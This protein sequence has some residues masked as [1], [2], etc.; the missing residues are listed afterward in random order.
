M[1]KAISSMDDLV[2]SENTASLYLPPSPPIQLWLRI[3]MHD[4]NKMYAMISIPRFDYANIYNSAQFSPSWLD[5][6]I[7]MV[8]LPFRSAHV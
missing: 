4:K 5:I 2:S 8:S 7:E 3:K 6:H 1:A